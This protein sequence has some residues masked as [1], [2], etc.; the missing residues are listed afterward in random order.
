MVSS[1]FL[2]VFG[3]HTWHVINI[4]QISLEVAL[5]DISEGISFS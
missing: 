2:A 4:C 1:T 5:L 3:E